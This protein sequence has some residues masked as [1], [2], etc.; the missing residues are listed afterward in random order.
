MCTKYA[1]WDSRS[2]YWEWEALI[3]IFKVIWSFRLTNSTL[4]LYTALGLPSGATRPK[5]ALVII[6][7]RRGSTMMHRLLDSGGY[8]FTQW[9]DDAYMGPWTRSSL[10]QVIAVIWSAPSYCITKIHW[11]MSSAKYRPFCPSL[12]VLFEHR[13]QSYGLSFKR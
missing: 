11:T 3:F 9:P 10:V 6:W 5:R 2:W 8:F 7:S 1:S 13:Y 12:A 4:P